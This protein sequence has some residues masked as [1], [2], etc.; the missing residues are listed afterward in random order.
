MLLRVDERSPET[1]MRAIELTMLDGGQ[2]RNRTADASLFRAAL[3]QLSYLAI[4]G[5]QAASA[6]AALDLRDTSEMRWKLFE[7]ACKY[8]KDMQGLLNYSNP[9]HLVKNSGAF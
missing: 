8:K 3:Y 5:P 2:G 9:R 4:L 7:P 6:K 1:N